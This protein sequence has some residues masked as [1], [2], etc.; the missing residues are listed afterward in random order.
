MVMVARAGGAAGGGEGGSFESS[1]RRWARF[2]LW[3][4][5]VPCAVV[6]TDP[7]TIYAGWVERPKP[8]FLRRDFPRASS[9]KADGQIDRSIIGFIGSSLQGRA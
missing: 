8:L 1:A 3:E 2:F 4:G 7:G 6:V 9:G 5:D